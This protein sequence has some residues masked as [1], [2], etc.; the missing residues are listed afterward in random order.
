MSEENTATEATA[1]AG[2]ASSSRMRRRTTKKVDYA[3]E[4]E[5][6][7]EDIFEDSADEDAP[8]SRGRK[9]KGGGGS[10]GRRS[11]GG[12]SSMSGTASNRRSV[13]TSSNALA[14]DDSQGVNDSGRVYYTETGYDPT[15]P[16]IKER[17]PFLP[18]FEEDGTPKIDL[19]VGRRPVDEN[20]DVDPTEKKKKGDD[21][22]DQDEDQDADEE[23][24]EAETESGSTKRS[25]RRSSRR[26]R[27]STLSAKKKGS[28]KKEIIKEVSSSGPT[29]YEYLVKYRGRSYLHLEWKRGADLESMNKSAKGIYRRYL[30]KIAQGTEEDLENP[31]FDPAY[32]VPQKIVDEEEQEI[33]VELT[34]KELL[35]WEKQREKEIAM[36]AAEEEEDGKTEN[37]TAQG[38]AAV[39]EQNNA[40]CANNTDATMEEEKKGTRT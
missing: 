28:P 35:K 17:F 15:L 25:S 33:T 22:D 36:A 31:E 8:S 29:E 38:Q 18:E 34:D 23:E 26:S 39:S 2:E 14:Q 11:K 27:K 1:K 7:D 20:E 10:G 6:S 40:A 19:I 30:K 12:A 32:A 24:E 5:F 3:K 13:G 4:Q 37:E 21:E 9:S 16:P